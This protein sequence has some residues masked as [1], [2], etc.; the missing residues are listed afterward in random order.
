MSSVEDARE[1]LT[2]NEAATLINR[3]PQTVRR[4]ICEGKLSAQK[5][6]GAGGSEWRIDRKSIEALMVSLQGES[7]HGES[8]I[9]Y[10][11]SRLAALEEMI[12][13]VL[14]AQKALSPALEEAAT[15]RRELDAERSRA[16]ALAREAEALREA[17][18]AEK[19]RS[20]W[21]RLWGRQHRKGMTDHVDHPPK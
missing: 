20:W 18:A 15:M 14:E 9:R 5:V 10:A 1:G 19:R 3:D 13:Q 2:V 17:L 7:D 6:Q 21:E 4:Y 11:L 16:Q 12:T 8:A